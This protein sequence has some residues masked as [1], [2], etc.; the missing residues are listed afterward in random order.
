MT[1]QTAAPRP[2]LE[3]AG[4]ATLPRKL[5]DFSGVATRIGSLYDSLGARAAEEHG[6]HPAKAA[7]YFGLRL[8]GA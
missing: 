3:Q 4:D 7:G 8:S 5:F 2:R 6:K 1:Q